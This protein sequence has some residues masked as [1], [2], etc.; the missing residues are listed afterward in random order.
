MEK[1]NLIKLYKAVYSATVEISR[2]I[3]LNDFLGIKSFL[4]AKDELI[5]RINEAKEKITLS[6]EEKEELNSF[7][8]VIRNLEDKNLQVM[9]I[10]QKDL[11]E[12]ISKINKG[13]KTLSS[14]KVN[15]EIAPAII[16]KRE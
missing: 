7:I 10:K 4:D 14:Y 6:T 3:D 8:S 11:K 2:L 9:E 16:D 5:K 1:E 13:S 12:E 15:K